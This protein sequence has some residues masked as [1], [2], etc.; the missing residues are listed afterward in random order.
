[1]CA[2]YGQNPQL[3]PTSRTAQTTV[4]QTIARVP[5]ADLEGHYNAWVDACLA[6]YGSDKEKN[7]S[8]NFKV[9][10]PLTE[11][12]LMGNLA[13]RAYDIRHPRA[14]NGFDFPGRHIKLLWDGT[15]MKIT[16]FEEANQ[17]VRRTYRQ[18]WSL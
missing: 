5:G 11:S 7:L 8:S 1:M 17:F 6:G 14:N 16:N 10:G 18:G 15:N 4:P 12:V 9:A 13:I 2:T 3:L